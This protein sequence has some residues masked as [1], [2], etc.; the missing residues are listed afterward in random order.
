MRFSLVAL[1]AVLVLAGCSGGTPERAAVPEPTSEPTIA[2][3]LRMPEQGQAAMRQAL[4]LVPASAQ[5]V[6]LTDLDELRERFGLLELTSDSLRADSSEFWSRAGREAVLLTEGLLRPLESTYRLDHGFS[7]DD[8]DWEVRF[9]GERG[10]GYVVGFRP[11]QDMAEVRA[12]VD[13]GVGSLAD[14][15]VIAAQ[16]LLVE[17]VARDD[18]P[19]WAETIG[20]PDLLDDEA[21]STYLR[22]DCIPV[23]DA[24]GPDADAEDQARLARVMYDLDPLDAFSV[25]FSDDVMT[26]RLG[27]G[28]SD[29]HQRADL[30]ALWPEE[31]GFADG[32]DGHQAADP[33][34]G[35]IGLRI[36]DPL[37][38]ASLTLTGGLPFAVCEEL[39]PIPEPTGL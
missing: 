8:V 32:F 38:A 14:A 23:N 10:S 39:V 27:P 31:V 2:R 36:D 21:E 24:L 16:R 5:V 19:V 28:R 29:L 30:S 22:N 33:V 15:T 18:E 35:R 4:S 9:T 26:A 34:T 7:Q 37:K 1:A 6:V 13:A 12:A 3:S 20:L 17:G 25:S 11:G